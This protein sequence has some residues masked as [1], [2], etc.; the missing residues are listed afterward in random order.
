M[1][2]R[3]REV[4]EKCKSHKLIINKEARKESVRERVFVDNRS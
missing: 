2:V 1:Y 4:G 3:R